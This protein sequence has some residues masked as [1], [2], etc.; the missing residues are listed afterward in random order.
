MRALYRESPRSWTLS[1]INIGAGIDH[2]P[3]CLPG[4]AFR[5]SVHFWCERLKDFWT[6]LGGGMEIGDSLIV[7]KYS[8]Y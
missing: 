7:F 8:I 2:F 5:R 6:F 1:A 4:E 3:S